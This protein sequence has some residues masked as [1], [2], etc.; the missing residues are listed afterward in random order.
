MPLEDRIRL[1]IK[2]SGLSSVHHSER[3]LRLRR[4]RTGPHQLLMKN[5]TVCARFPEFDITSSP[6]LIRPTETRMTR[7]A[8]NS[9]RP[10]F[11]ILITTLRTRK[12]LSGTGLERNAAQLMI[13]S[14]VATA[15]RRSVSITP[16]N[17]TTRQRVDTAR[18]ADPQMQPSF[19]SSKLAAQPVT[20]NS[21]P[22]P[23]AAA[24]TSTARR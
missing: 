18:T 6:R 22:R 19:I 16:R 9:R 12:L 14:C 1:V 10:R 21:S 4:R 20:S 8:P 3:S 2:R 13:L 5:V 11:P 17:R 15:S 7:R 23:D 24:G